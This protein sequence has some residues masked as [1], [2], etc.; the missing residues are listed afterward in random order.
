M[1]QRSHAA[2]YL[3]AAW[4]A[5]YAALR[6][7]WTLG[8]DWL[9][10]R[11][12]AEEAAKA[13][14]V[15]LCEHRPLPELGAWAGWVSVAALAALAV[16]ALATVRPFGRRIGR[17]WL[18]AASW[19]GA[20]ALLSLG[21]EL[22]LLNLLRVA[23]WFTGLPGWAT[24]PYW[25]LVAG[26]LVVLAGVVAFA[27]AARSHQLR[28][29][30][31][32]V[33]VR[34]AT[35]WF[36]RFGWAAALAPLPYVTLK[37]VWALGFPV[38]GYH[39]S[40]LV[41]EHHWYSP[42]TDLSVTVPLFGTLCA[43]AL[44]RGWAGWVPRPLVLGAAWVGGVGLLSMGLPA[45]VTTIG[46]AAGLAEFPTAP[47]SADLWVIALTYGGFLCWGAALIGLVIFYQA[48][49]QPAPSQ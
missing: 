43:V 15:D 49:T 22:L 37:A 34:A 33:D 17:A 39:E 5:A 25:T 7:Y 12:G 48:L 24:E 44:I 28:T 23:L 9:A 30:P 46:V 4:A 31:E 36:H 13:T 8:G 20:L 11:C 47:G 10:A 2:G 29:R 6:G 14:A 3:A 16:L 21:G 42:L 45:A 41:G 40:G 32:A 18:L 38:G 19:S 27:A 35:R 1:R 26:Q